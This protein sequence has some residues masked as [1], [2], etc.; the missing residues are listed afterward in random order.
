MS[1]AIQLS[2]QHK[3]KQPKAATIQLSVQHKKKQPKAAT[4][5][6][7]PNLQVSGQTLAELQEIY[8][9]VLVQTALELRC[10]CEFPNPKKYYRLTSKMETG[11]H[12]GVAE[13]LKKS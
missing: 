1:H 11:S 6:T 13:G 4:T 9:E 8:D 12:V 5:R 2:V 3:K 10:E 7:S